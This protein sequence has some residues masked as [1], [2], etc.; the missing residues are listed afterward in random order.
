MIKPVKRCLT[1]ISIILLLGII[2]TGI[3]AN[4][5][6][7]FPLEEPGF[8]LAKNMTPANQ[9]KSFA[10][11]KALVLCAKL[12]GFVDEIQTPTF[13]KII[14]NSSPGTD[15]RAVSY[16]TDSTNGENQ[17]I[18]IAADAFD[19]WG[20]DSKNA[21]DFLTS[22][23]Y[24]K[25]KSDNYAC[26]IK[27]TFSVYD[28]AGV[29]QKNGD[30]SRKNLV[31]SNGQYV[32]ESGDIIVPNTIKTFSWPPS[33]DSEMSNQAYEA[34]T[35]EL[36]DGL[37]DDKDDIEMTCRMYFS[38]TDYVNDPN[39]Y[40]GTPAGDNDDDG[41]GVINDQDV[42]S[43]MV[44]P[45]NVYTYHAPS[46]EDL[47]NNL[48]NE[49]KWHV[50]KT[51]S[52]E[53][54]SINDTPGLAYYLYYYY[55]YNNDKL[56]KATNYIDLSASS[57][58]TN[59][60]K[61]AVGIIST[62]AKTL[63]KYTAAWEQPGY[64][65]TAPSED[66]RTFKIFAGDD[67]KTC[68]QIGTVLGAEADK[69]IADV[70]VSGPGKYGA[71]FTGLSS[72]AVDAGEIGT[73]AE[74]N[75]VTPEETNS[76]GTQVAGV[77]WIMCPVLN[78]LVSLN[79]GVWRLVTGLLTVSP[80]QQKAANGADSGAYAAWGMIRNIANIVFVIIFLVMIFS[81]L[82]SA[83]IS[84][85]GIK[86]LLPR[87][88]VGAILVNISF[89]II[90]LA[91]DLSNIIGSGLY[92]LIQGVTPYAPPGWATLFNQISIAGAGVAVVGVATVFAAGN[93]T[94]FWMLL[95]IAAV[96]LLGLIA[97]IVTLVFRKAVIIILA[98]L[99]PMAIVAS[100]LPNTESW[101]KKW[102]DEF[103]QLLLLYPLAAIVF[104]G[105]QFAASIIMSEAP[106]NWMNNLMAMV[107]TTLPLFSLPFLVTKGGKI[108]STAGSALSKLAEKARSPLK[109]FAKSYEDEARSKYLAGDPADSRTRLGAARQNAYKRFSRQR[110]T[111]ES[112]TKTNT[113]R[114]GSEWA[115]STEGQE[116]D[117]RA[118]LAESQSKTDKTI[119]QMRMHRS[120][121]GQAALD[122][123]KLTDTSLQRL[124]EESGTRFSQSAD[125]TDALTR[126]GLAKKQTTVDSDAIATH[127]D[128][129][130]AGR[131]LN[132]TISRGKLQ[133]NIDSTDTENRVAASVAG[134]ALHQ[135]L[136][137]TTQSSTI[138]KQAIAHDLANSVNGM[139]NDRQIGVGKI[140]AEN[141]TI[142]TNVDVA[143]SQAGHDENIVQGILK[144]RSNIE[145]N[146]TAA[147]VETSTSVGTRLEQKAAEANLKAAKSSTD[148]LATEAATSSTA[149][150]LN[151]IG[152][153]T[154]ATLQD[155]KRRL[156]LTNIASANAQR[157]QQNELADV[158]LQNTTTMD[159]QS[160]RDFAGGIDTEKGADSALANAI[161]TKREAH[162]K[163]IGERSQLIKHFNVDGANRQAI[164]MGM[165]V[166]N[167]DTGLMEDP[168]GTASDGTEYVFALGDKN[169]QEA[170]I[171]KQMEIGSFEEFSKII[172]A[173]GGSL[174]EF[175]TVIADAIPKYGINK[176]GPQFGGK[177]IN[178][179]SQGGVKGHEYV[180]KGAAE[181]LLDG[182]FQAEDLANSDA[183]SIKTFIEA[184]QNYK[185][186]TPDG[187]PI[188]PQIGKDADGNP[189]DNYAI[190]EDRI[191]QLK[192]IADL[193]LDD[194]ST[195]GKNR[196]DAATK[197]FEIIKNTTF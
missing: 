66:T 104:G 128:N 195:V 161:A 90:Q 152:A 194:K 119:A 68:M 131:V 59:P 46:K 55:F 71:I 176:K 22:L 58:A 79:D 53:E 94:A 166:L 19:F 88:I 54:I 102:K 93:A 196:T 21:G 2:I 29:E 10:Y 33:S 185:K 154:R 31:I 159:G 48:A 178:T 42:H 191:K 74:D 171:E 174:S 75:P 184:A 183:N 106:S 138:F 137:E 99:A 23:G 76:C 60:N 145:D 122:T 172:E 49:I 81:Q 105:S 175:K 127:T 144:I 113:M 139:A 15:F 95:P 37:Q 114:F 63:N 85:Y 1:N 109:N 107:I 4:K 38:Q 20:F 69:I 52:D 61:L 140:L 103:I 26:L 136:G 11:Y 9:V 146:K 57:L 77:G 173:S 70:N 92:G 45:G 135:R 5:T 89:L 39:K 17:C 187:K 36:K 67:A 179:V 147:E 120:T 142:R 149:A 82:S 117:D 34:S 13:E 141:D 177:M 84:N 182:K 44:I 132:E 50:Y 83:G 164:A 100:L 134:Q 186:N 157:V 35:D 43:F 169:S 41:N 168:K 110:M 111:R 156:D 143:Q 30:G 78:G 32:D 7:A 124:K 130:A 8:T 51:I 64:T 72:Q 86:K 6:N 87:L 118:L 192:A 155:A 129:T 116:A 62:D 167:K 91:V 16:L 163:V 153:T 98:V 189:V 27:T 160:V 18:N 162:N 115:N 3:Y 47:A 101:F 97:A 108:M 65:A 150:H 123:E 193:V 96:G 181:F 56:C 148:L 40:M 197:Q 170:A 190:M 133:S 125:G 188:I 180:V 165:Q 25:T 28:S 121:E 24:S 80:L 158:L 14:K 73:I 126:L 151:N 12:G 112:N